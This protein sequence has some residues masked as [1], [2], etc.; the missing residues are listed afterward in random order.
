[1]KTKALR[2]LVFSAATGLSLAAAFAPG[3]AHALTYNGEVLQYWDDQGSHHVHYPAYS[4]YSL[5]E[6][7][8]D[9]SSETE[10]VIGGASNPTLIADNKTIDQRNLGGLGW[11]KVG[12][13]NAPGALIMQG[14]SIGY[15][16]KLGVGSHSNGDGRL[17][18]DASTVEVTNE[19]YVGIRSYG[20][21]ILHQ[22][23][24]NIEGNV[25]IGPSASEGA[26][27]G[28]LVVERNSR[29]FLGQSLT[30]TIGGDN[31]GELVVGTKGII[32]TA[33]MHGGPS[34]FFGGHSTFTIGLDMSMAGN[35]VAAAPV[36]VSTV[37]IER[38]AK[39][40]VD[41][42]GVWLTPG[43]RYTILTA[44][45]ITGDF[46]Q[47]LIDPSVVTSD[48]GQIFDVRYYGTEVVLIPTASAIPEPSTYALLGGAGAVALAML[49]RRRRRHG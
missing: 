17:L 44:G 27:S 15:F 33:Y 34:I 30:M 8:R 3:V 25:R 9:P 29:L 37:Q 18:I 23:Y 7:V 39:L 24:M 11:L 10:S 32:Q 46:F 36:Q 38:S 41:T 22:A 42:D 14:G 6:N 49:R 2:R 13:S 21:M 43:D 20:E 31:D 45:S 40:A 4:P 47:G 19:L 1:M 26:G 16:I 28:K 5:P 12:N 35:G 48:T